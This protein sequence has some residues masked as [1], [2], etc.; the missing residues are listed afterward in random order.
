MKH[1]I[2]VLALVACA[3]TK[4]EEA[5]RAAAEYVTRIPGATSFECAKQDTNSDGYCSCTVFRKDAD[6]L[7]IECGCERWCIWNCARGCKYTP[8]KGG[9]Q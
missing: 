4:P 9:K 3:N 6:P 2:L 1:L 7:S 8:F 5:N